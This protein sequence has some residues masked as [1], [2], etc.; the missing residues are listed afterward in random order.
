M[1]DST[2]LYELIEKE[3]YTHGRDMN[4]VEAIKFAKQV[5]F[6]VLQRD[7]KRQKHEEMLQKEEM[8]ENQKQ[9]KKDHYVCSDILSEI[10]T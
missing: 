5:A 4:S 2:K 3:L 7:R 9:A 6:K 8:I 1:Y 10:S